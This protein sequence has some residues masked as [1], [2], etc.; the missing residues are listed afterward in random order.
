MLRSL[1]QNTINKPLLVTNTS[2]LNCGGEL[3]IDALVNF[4]QSRY[5]FIN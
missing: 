4:M 2:N 1:S 3:F 5:Y